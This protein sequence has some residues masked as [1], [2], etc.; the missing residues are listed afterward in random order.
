M[1]VEQ[2]LG[3]ETR[4]KVLRTLFQDALPQ[5]DAG[6]LAGEAG[7][8]VAGVRKALAET[9]SAGVVLAHQRG[10]RVFYAANGAHPW[11][12]VLL[13]LFR[14][15]RDSN[16]V[17][18]LFPTFW[19]H[20]EGVVGALTKSE[21][22]LVVALFGSL[23]RPPIYPDADVDLLV[24]VASKSAIPSYSGEILGHPVSVLVLET[25]ALER[26]VRQNDPF[27]TGA[28]ERHVVLYQAPGYE[29]P[30]MHRRLAT[31]T[32]RPRRQRGVR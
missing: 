13:Q 25:E 18:H 4:T 27:I 11:F 28:L 12:P 16:N 17:A 6:A 19:N 7:K 29:P 10:R 31:S 20:I 8:S 22:V 23:M 21:G 1:H 5:L 2:A 3:S 26:K 14:H 24:G 30:W 15:E 9:Q 32:D